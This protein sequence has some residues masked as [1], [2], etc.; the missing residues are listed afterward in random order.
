MKFFIALP[1]LAAAAVAAPQLEAGD[2]AN[3]T[4]GL[5]PATA[6]DDMPVVSFHDYNVAFT[7]LDEATRF[8]NRYM[9]VQHLTETRV[10]DDLDEEGN[11]LV[12]KLSEKNERRE[13]K[14][15]D[16]IEIAKSY[17]KN[18]FGGKHDA[19]VEAVIEEAKDKLHAAWT[20][21]RIRDLNQLSSRNLF[22]DHSP[23]K[24]F[25]I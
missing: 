2:N 9:L 22:K 24:P 23:K 4:T 12:F 25:P 1:L 21:I 11:N 10:D 20:D 5:D 15:R 8:Y 7:F 6:V 19:K 14:E 3:A 13:A 16:M 18:A 17:F